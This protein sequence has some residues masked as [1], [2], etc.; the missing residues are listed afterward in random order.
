LNAIPLNLAA[1]KQKLLPQAQR[2]GDLVTEDHAAQEFAR[3]H[4]GQL[5]YDHSTGSWYEWTGAVWQ[6]NC[7]RRAFHWAREL[8]RKLAQSEPDRIRYA[9]CKTGF[10]HGVEKFSQADPAFAVTAEI[11]DRDPYM[12][13]TPGGTVDLRT[14]VLRAADPN[15]NITKLAAIA[16]SAKGDCPRWKQFLLE[17]CG[18]DIERVRFLHQIFG[19]CLTGDTREHALFFIYGPG[20]NGKSVFLNV[21]AG[22]IGSYAV[23]A[24]MDTFTASKADKHP[25]ELAMLKGSRLV[26][27]SET[28]EG[29]AWA[30]SRIKSLTGGDPIT[31]RFMR[32]DFFSF[33]PQFK[34]VVTGNHKPVLN[35]VDDAARRRFNIVPF[36]HKPVTPDRELERK[37]KE[38]YPAILRWA[39]EG[40]LDWQN[41]GLVRPAS[42]VAETNAYFSDQDLFGQ[43]IEDECDFEPGNNYKWESVSGL[44]SAWTNYATKAGEKPTSKKS[45]SENLIRRGLVS[46]RKDRGTVR[47]FE[48]VRLIQR[49]AEFSNDDR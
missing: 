33:Q 6:T 47:A 22:V 12:F 38:E 37:L 11:W 31:A 5:R 34:L 32:Q 20:G 35:N 21:L 28:E 3:L 49:G 30:E 39:I 14:G 42:V 8:A 19:Y 48:G 16:P 40:C 43:W 17:A 46:C 41:S 45:F 27:A 36:V 2:Q 26:S 7:T 1:R 10:A 4:S 25:T 24:A 23:T 13:G 15:D 29:R 9:T 18:G 44:F